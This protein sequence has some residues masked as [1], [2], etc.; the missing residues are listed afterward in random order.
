MKKKT[1]L[2]PLNV[3]RIIFVL[4]A[5]CSFSNFLCKWIRKIPIYG[6]FLSSLSL[7]LSVVL[8]FA[9]GLLTLFNNKKKEEKGGLKNSKDSFDVSTEYNK[10]KHTQ[11][12]QWEQDFKE[13]YF[14][15]K[16]NLELKYFQKFLINKVR[17][18]KNTYD[19]SSAVIIPS[20]I[21]SIFSMDI[22]TKAEETIDLASLAI[23]V[24]VYI[25]IMVF[26]LI[27]TY[28]HISFFE[29]CVELCNEQIILNSKTK[30]LAEVNIVD[31][32]KESDEKDE[33]ITE[34]K[35]ILVEQRNYKT[36]ITITIE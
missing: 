36:I 6:E 5:L 9:M 24:G 11:Y 28:D 31:N 21:T 16:T 14:S 7:I 20:C 27:E 23:G 19:I 29:E 32:K 8:L 34:N 30:P 4:L 1:W 25:G 15:N 12:K 17:T 3:T 22:I 2:T 10:Y 26:E 18:Y 33:D 13:T 35:D